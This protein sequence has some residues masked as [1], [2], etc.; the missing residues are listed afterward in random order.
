MKSN[1]SKW[2]LLLI[3]FGFILCLISCIPANTSPKAREDYE[4]EV[5]GIAIY[6]GYLYVLSNRYFPD[7]T[8][9][10]HITKID[11][12]KRKVVDRIGLPYLAED[13]A[14]DDGILYVAYWD[15]PAKIGRIDLSTF[16][17][18]GLYYLPHNKSSACNLYVLD[19]YIYVS[20][21]ASISR[22]NKNTWVEDG[23]LDLG[24]GTG[25]WEMVDTDGTYLYA[26]CLQG[27]VAKIRISDF[28]LIS[29]VVLSLK[30][31]Q[32]IIYHNGYIYTIHRYI[33]GKMLKL[34]ASTLSEIGS[35]TFSEGNDNPKSGY[36]HIGS[37]CYAICCTNPARI[38][39]VNLD[40]FTEVVWC[41]AGK[42]TGREA[43][44]VSDDSLFIATD[45]T[46]HI[47]IFKIPYPVEINKENA[48]CKEVL[49]WRIE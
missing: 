30:D 18:N 42:D 9:K 16:N 1:I 21:S 7:R 33:P 38:V 35:I 45:T 12:V 2:P 19:K 24:K 22:V 13:I 44:E 20:G 32:G 43:I 11:Y 6:E 31:A 17:A 15:R 37:I 36:A 8:G 5:G 40:S 47:S 39:E 28:S 3:V 4:D 29:N 48:V 14:I 49:S 10:A 26:V 41:Y 25:L 27:R 46:S 23:F 34:D